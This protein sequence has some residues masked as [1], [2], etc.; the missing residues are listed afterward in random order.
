MVCILEAVLNMIMKNRCIALLLVLALLC[1]M[2]MTAQAEV[3]TLGI[4]FCGRRIAEDG[5]ETIVRLEGRFR[6]TQNGEE[7]G[8][9][10]AGKNTLTLAGTERI[11]IEPM[12]ESIAPE[13]DLSGAAREVTPEAGGTMT[14]S[15]VVEPLKT[16]KPAATAAPLPEETEVAG[17]TTEIPEIPVIP[18]TEEE[19]E[20]TGSVTVIQSTPAPARAVVTPTLPP[21]DTSLLEPTPEP[22]WIILAEEL[23]DL[24]DQKD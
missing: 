9:I 24:P 20:R 19:D 17:I 21:F 6:V 22:E 23:T 15:V 14:V 11:R 8:V 7:A 4:Y 5:S 10:D 12:A 3:V 16:E 18:E 1:G 13:W 2:I